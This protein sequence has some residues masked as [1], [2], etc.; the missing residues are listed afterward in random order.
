PDVVHA[1]SPVLVGLPAL[2]TAHD[3]GIPC[4]YEIRD[5]WENAS[6]DRGKFG[7]NSPQYLLARA[8]ETYVVTH[9]DAVVT[10]CQ[11]LR[12]ELASSIRDPLRL[13]VVENGVDVTAFQ[14]QT[15]SPE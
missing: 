7:Y 5:L 8:L 14:P 15:P 11:T 6:V 3:R 2:R 13:F 1:H 9:A 10:I 12:R 4:V